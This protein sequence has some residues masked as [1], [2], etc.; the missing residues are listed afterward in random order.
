MLRDGRGGVEVRERRGPGRRPLRRAHAVLR[1]A[2]ALLGAGA[3]RRGR[4][5]RRHLQRGDGQGG[6]ALLRQGRVRVRAPGSRRA[7]RHDPQLALRS[8]RDRARE[9]RDRR[10]DARE[11]R[12]ARATTWTSTSSCW[13]TATRR[14]AGSASAPRRR[15]R[16]RRARR[17][18]T[19]FAAC[20][21]RRGSSSASQAGMDESLA[22][23]RRG[24]VRRPRGRAGSGAGSDPG[25]ERR[26]GVS[27]SIPS[28]ST[29][30]T[31]ASG[32][33]RIRS[34]TPTSTSSSSCRPSSA[35]ACPP[36]SPRRSPCSAALP[37]RSTAWPPP[38]PT[39]GRCSRRA[40]STS[41]RSTTPSR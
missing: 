20:T 32:C 8:L 19:S 27:C 2:A 39:S 37:T 22:R 34:A 28:P 6:D 18:S 38:T 16:R 17:S 15:S 31:C 41:T 35:A 26:R 21:S 36:G 1:D 7:G 40:A 5:D 9:G 13:C 10:G 24:A 14:W 11:V 12:R 4:C 30:R 25:G 3:H 23:G 29:R 33:G